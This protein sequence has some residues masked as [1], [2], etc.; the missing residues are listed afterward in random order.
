MTT[1][2]RGS[3]SYRK[4]KHPGHPG[5]FQICWLYDSSDDNLP[6]TYCRRSVSYRKVKHP[7]YPGYSKMCWLY[8]SSDVYR[9]RVRYSSNFRGGIVSKAH[10]P[11]YHSTLGSRVIKK[12]EKKY[13]RRAAR[14]TTSFHAVTARVASLWCRRDTCLPTFLITLEPRVE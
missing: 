11:L 12:K 9:R 3:V 5:Y 10:G 4:V 7:G 2:C 1:Y 14:E 13:R 8:N 6:G